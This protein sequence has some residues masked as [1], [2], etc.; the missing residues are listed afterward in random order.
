MDKIELEIAALSQSV[1]QSKSYAVVLKE[2]GGRRRLP[3][4]IGVPEAQAIALALEDMKPSRPLTHD[5]IKNICDSFSIQLKE[6]VIS[7]LLDGIFHSKLICHQDGNLL[8]VD[9]RTSDALALA[10]RFKCPIFTYEQILDS[11]GIILE[12]EAASNIPA[13]IEPVKKPVAQVSPANDYSNHSPSKLNALLQDA[14]KKED[15]EMAAR[16][17]DELERRK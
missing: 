15:Y 1:T 16:I 4:V 11:A 17:R 5:L 14:L 2:I 6:I 3:I 13:D 12:S 7:E 9:S 8:E 10:A